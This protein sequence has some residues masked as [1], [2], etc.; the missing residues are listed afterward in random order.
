MS[1]T[2]VWYAA[3]LMVKR[4]GG[5]AMLEAAAR[6]DQLQEDGD[7]AGCEAWHRILNAHPSSLVA[8]SDQHRNRQRVYVDFRR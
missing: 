3:V 5:G 8:C 4:Y 7:M 1:E 6:A 2:A